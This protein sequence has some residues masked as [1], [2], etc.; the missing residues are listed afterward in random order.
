MHGETVARTIMG[1]ETEYRPGVWFNSAKFFDIEYQTYGHVWPRLKADEE[2]FYW[3]HKAGKKCLKFVYNRVNKQILGINCL[4]IRFRHQVIDQWIKEKRDI[5]YVMKNLRMA[6]FDP[7]FSKS[8]KQELIR[9]FNLQT[10]EIPVKEARS[11][12]LGSLF[13]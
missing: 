1:Q 7:E 5:F 12:F 4:G 6:N 8:H 10:S 3:E 11:G 9:K 13:K 2:Q